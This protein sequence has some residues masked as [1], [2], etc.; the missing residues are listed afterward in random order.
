ME[1]TSD[2]LRFG[3]R[4]MEDPHAGTW[5]DGQWSKAGGDTWCRCQIRQ[6]LG[7][8]SRT[9]RLRLMVTGGRGHDVLPWFGP[10]RWR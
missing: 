4:T 7:R 10:S 5:E 6:I 2:E 3:Q 1:S 9:M 8:R